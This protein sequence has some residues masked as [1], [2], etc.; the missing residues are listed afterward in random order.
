MGRKRERWPE[1][2]DL[3]HPDD[4]LPVRDAGIWT[5]DKLWYWNRYL[6]ITTS[7]MVGNPKWDGGI[8][9]VDLFGGPGV[10]QI[11]DSRRRIPGSALLAANTPKPFDKLIV[12]EK[13]EQLAR[14]CK[15]RLESAGAGDRSTILVGDCND[16]IDEVVA[17]IPTRAL[18]LAF[19]DPEGLHIHFQTIE[20][21]AH[22]RKVDLL[23]LFAD[24]MD[25]VRN[26]AFYAQQSESNLDRFLG[27][28]CDWR[29][30]WQNLPNQSREN[31]CKLFQEIY[32]TQLNQKLGYEVFADQVMRSRTTAIYRVI[33]ASKHPKGLEFWNKI[34]RIDRS[35]QQTLFG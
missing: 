28:D 31:V 26:V 25:L 8:I 11:R 35:G 14:V 30:Q 21:L 24:S 19:I 27:S 10:I 33:Y 12:C 34:S 4:G 5:E 1:L 6:E 9:Y 20:K 13:D 23:V 3:V 2:C 18:T 15:T 29:T 16:L 22:G 7:A 32:Q 17:A